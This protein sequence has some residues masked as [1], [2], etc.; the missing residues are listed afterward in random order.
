MEWLTAFFVSPAGIAAKALL[1]GTILTFVLGVLA[2]VRDGTFGWSYVD[3]FVKD[4]L[5]L[6]VGPVTV[7]LI[8]AYFANDATVLAPAVIAAGAVAAGMLNAIVDSIRQLTMTK[9]ASASANV[10]PGTP[11]PAKT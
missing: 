8:G 6:K 7:V 10:L 4:P 3:A 2:A 9:P 1:L 11:P 5:A